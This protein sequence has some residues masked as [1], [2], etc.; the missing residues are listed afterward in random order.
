MAS[1]TFVTIY[2][3]FVSKGGAQDMAISIAQGL[4]KK[5][6]PIILYD[7]P[8]ICKEYREAEVEFVRFSIRSITKYHKDGCIFLSHHR[9][10]TTYLRLLSLCLFRNNLKIVHVAHNTFSTL[11]NW[12]LFPK[13]IIA[14][15]H[16]VKKNL[17]DYFRIPKERIKV[18]YNGMIDVYSP[19]N[20]LDLNT[21]VIKI[22]LLGRIDPVK[23]QLEFVKETI[24]KLDSRIKIYFGGIGE[25]YS[26]LKA[27]TEKTN[28][29]I[30]LGLIDVKRELYKYDYVCLFSEKEGLP[31]SLIEGCM[32][33][34]PLLTNTIPS[35]LEVNR[36]NYNGIA[37]STWPKIINMLNS[38]VNI[39]ISDYKVLCNNS[40]KLYEQEFNYDI[41][42]D[43]YRNYLDTII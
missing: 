22:I 14:V 31:L 42:I 16:T 30:C 32:F 19:N 6:K 1:R 15:S 10:M 35:V 23:R 21:E 9:K 7:N 29:Y 17:I 18:I 2:P 8:N 27:I 28:Q 37:E 13:N 12:T 38:L 39:P 25:D 11:R 20:K 33:A 36:V 26:K 3:R 40:R 4:E 41:M 34:K 43:R 24:G 5:I